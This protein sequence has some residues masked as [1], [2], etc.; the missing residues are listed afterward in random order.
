MRASDAVMAM[1]PSVRVWYEIWY[2]LRTD[3]R[4]RVGHDVAEDV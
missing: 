3:A 1:G 4:Q 2:R